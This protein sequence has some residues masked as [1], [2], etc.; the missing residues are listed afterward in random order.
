MTGMVQMGRK[1]CQRDSADAPDVLKEDD[2]LP[3]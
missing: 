2:L 3:L 1:F